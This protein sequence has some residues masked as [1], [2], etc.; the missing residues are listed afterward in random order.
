MLNHHQIFKPSGILRE[1]TVTALSSKSSLIA[2]RYA[3]ALVD[4][5]EE[6]AAVDKV[7][8]DLVD[9]REM[10]EGS[11]DLQAVIANPLSNSEQQKNAMIKIADKAGF[12]KITANF[13]AVLAENRRLIDILSI[14][15]AFAKE[16]S[17]RRDEI[18][19]T[20]KSATTL[21]AAQTKDLQ[22]QLSKVM[23][24]NVTLNVEVDKDLLGGMVV[25]VGSLMVDDSVRSKLERLQRAMNANE[26]TKNTK[27]KEVS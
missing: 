9:L 19:A 25:T 16:L 17:S 3:S 27:M 18:E 23:G 26:N 4:V 7:S 5:A 21:S 12:Q 24:S 8:G 2:S 14:I 6:G 1:I 11:S 15:D 22:K 10:I 13:L 20:I